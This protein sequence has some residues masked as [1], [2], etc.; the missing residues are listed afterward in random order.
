[1][2]QM[3]TR[4]DEESLPTS[5]LVA[6]HLAMLDWMN[7]RRPEPAPETWALSIWEDRIERDPELAWPF[8]LEIVRM[9]PAD[10]E[11]LEH[12]WTRL[13][14]LLRNHGAA[15]RDRV[16]A[17]VESNERL[18]RIVPPEDLTPGALRPD[19]LDVPALV[20]AYLTMSEH[21]ESAHELDELIRTDPDHALTLALEIISRGPLNGLTS[22]DTMSPLLDLLRRHG[23]AIIDR[24]EDAASESVLVRRC[25]WR[26]RRQQS[27][28]PS[29]YDIVPAVW[30]RVERA[31]RGT[32]DYNT[33]DPAGSAHSLPPDY[34]RVVESWFVHQETFWAWERVHDFVDN[35]PELAWRVV[36]LLAENAPSDDILEFIA[37]GPLEDLLRKHGEHFVDRVEEW[38]RRDDR[39]RECLGGVWL[40]RGEL[41]ADVE[42]RL[43]H[44]S[45]DR[46]LLA[47]PI[48]DEAEWLREQRANVDEY[49]SRYGAQHRRLGDDPAWS[50]DPMLALWAVESLH[51]PGHVEHWAIASDFPTDHVALIDAP[52]P[53]AAVRLIAKSWAEAAEYIDRGQRHPDLD[54]GPP[55]TWPDLAPRLQRLAE[56]LGAIADDDYLWRS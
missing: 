20:Q 37:A 35:D 25:L 22:F 11:V 1:M 18:R 8:F 56:W 29:K 43:V 5:E 34:E 28:P 31:I 7:Q 46:I 39:F 41:P 26:M 12:M 54:C 6:R 14:Q 32:T 36:M 3:P 55:E 53:R 23:E 4:E 13:R 33:D 21:S 9:R 40:S 42:Q 27:N 2:T 17:L 24:V 10:D 47:E 38:A 45:G 44:A 51:A 16:A 50:M 48:P 30:E 52:D 15:F 49:L 19:P